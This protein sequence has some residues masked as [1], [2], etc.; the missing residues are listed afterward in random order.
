MATV[1]H[2]APNHIPSV[3]RRTAI[4]RLNARIGFSYNADSV[5]ENKKERNDYHAK[6]EVPAD[7]EKQMRQ[8]IECW[9]GTKVTPV[10]ASARLLMM[11]SVGRRGARF[12]QCKGGR[13]VKRPALRGDQRAQVANPHTAPRRAQTK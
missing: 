6:S 9:V 8:L 3:G 5:T 1:V 11:N 12:P 4:K 7:L 10:D 13:Q 2:F